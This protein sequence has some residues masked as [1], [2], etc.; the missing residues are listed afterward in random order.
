[1]R[2]HVNSRVTTIRSAAGDEFCRSCVVLLADAVAEGEAHPRHL[3]AIADSLRL[4]N[5]HPPEFA[6]L[7]EQYELDDQGR[8][9]CRPGPLRSGTHA[10]C[11]AE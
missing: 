4:G 6:S 7:P 10:G 8:A 1:M 9:K 3:A 5:D 11:P 2:Q